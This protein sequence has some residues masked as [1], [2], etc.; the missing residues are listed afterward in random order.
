MCNVNG[1]KDRRHPL[2]LMA[3]SLWWPLSARLAIRFIQY[4][5]RVVA[6]CPRGHYLRYVEGIETCFAYSRLNSQAC[7][8]K[9][10]RELSPEIVIPCDDRVVLQLH[11]LH[12]KQP[13]LRAL[14]EGSLGNPSGFE[15]V[16][17]R[18]KLL[19]AA[20]SIGISIPRTKQVTSEEDL[21]TWFARHDGAAVLKLDGTWAGKGVAIIRSAQEAKE[22]F[23]ELSRPVGLMTTCKRL[24]VNRDP[25][26]L[27]SWKRQTRPSMII[28][29]W[30]EGQPANSMVACWNGE[31]VSMVSVEVL[32]SEGATGAAHLVR[33]IED[34]R[35]TKAA[36]LLAKKLQLS[37]FCGL[38][39]VLDKSSRLPYLIEV[40]PRATQL[41]HLP[42]VRGRDLASALCMKL[43]GQICETGENSVEGKV[44]AFF[45]K[46]DHWVA[47]CSFPSGIYNDVPQN[48]PQL[49]NELMLPSWPERQWISRIYHHFFPLRTTE[50]VGFNFEAEQVAVP[51]HETG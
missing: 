21:D 44:I 8:E 35:M 17:C 25:L 15:L 7:L 34:E 39:Y 32:A 1:F 50:P 11:E 16:D 42:L 10:I 14:I 6:I 26:S 36:I 13:D 49:V 20:Q 23:R 3:A 45:P 41:G 31:V 5:C 30:I 27:W 40:N 51:A 19:E 29:Q 4:G 28:Q 38:D 33:I 48:Q 12:R 37:G 18:A 2:V 9:V 24:V 47:R 43:S 46:A 22:A